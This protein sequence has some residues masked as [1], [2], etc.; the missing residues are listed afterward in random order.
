MFYET[1][2]ARAGYDSRLTLG[3]E[4]YSP[5][6]GGSYQIQRAV[7]RLVHAMCRVDGLGKASKASP[8]QFR[9]TTLAKR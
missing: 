9:I 2:D 1:R 6:T 3:T 5:L 8:T 4:H 7:P